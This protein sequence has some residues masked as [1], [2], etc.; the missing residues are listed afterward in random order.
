MV[1]KLERFDLFKTFSII[2][3]LPINESG[4]VCLHFNLIKKFLILL[5]NMLERGGPP[6]HD[7]TSRQPTNLKLDVS[8]PVRP[9]P[10]LVSW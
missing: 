8:I 1:N 4:A 6:R 9:V 2:I 7:Q 3:E 10:F 5:S